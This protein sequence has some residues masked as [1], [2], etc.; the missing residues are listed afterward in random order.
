[1]AGV[2]LGPDPI[3][4]SESQAHLPAPVIRDLECALEVP[5]PATSDRGQSMVSGL[6]DQLAAYGGIDGDQFQV[7]V[8]DE[9]A[10]RRAAR[11]CH[12]WSLLPVRSRVIDG[13]A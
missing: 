3:G 8:D 11:G 12:S 9:L 7:P 6:M 13:L 1:M 4:Q 10:Q 2:A 5:D